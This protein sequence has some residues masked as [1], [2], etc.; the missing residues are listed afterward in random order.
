MLLGE[1]VGITGEGV[2]QDLQRDV[3]IELL[4][5][6]AVNLT[7]SSGAERRKDAVRPD[8]RSKREVQGNMCGSIA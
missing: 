4:V 5:T 1:A 8:K 2:R 6:R 7:H 3:A